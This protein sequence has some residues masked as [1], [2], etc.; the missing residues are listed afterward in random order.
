MIKIKLTALILTLCLSLPI[1]SQEQ[2]SAPSS[3]PPNL[4]EA[5]DK[6]DK[7]IK[8]FRSDVSA[9]FA[10]YPPR[11]SDKN[12]QSDTAA[13]SSPLQYA[14]DNCFMM[15]LNMGLKLYKDWSAYVD[16]GINDQN[17]QRTID[18]MAKFG[19]N[20]FD[21]ELEYYMANG[22]IKFWED[23]PFGQAADEAIKSRPPDQVSD[24]KETWQRV[25][26]LLKRPIRLG[27]VD[28]VP[29]GGFFYS[30]ATVPLVFGSEIAEVHEHL[31]A[32]AESAAAFFDPA[33]DVLALGIRLGMA[34]ITQHEPTFSRRIG[35]GA[36]YVNIGFG[37]VRPNKKL[38][39]QASALNPDFKTAALIAHFG[40]KIRLGMGYQ[41]FITRSAIFY[42]LGGLDMNVNVYHFPFNDYFLDVDFLPKTGG[43]GPYLRAGVKF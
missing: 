1:F 31:T 35:E 37:R 22:R 43:I 33:A 9:A 16:F 28:G 25:T 29:F 4:T 21:L 34:G 24:Y 41:T 30:N 6:V 10:W 23:T 38:T 17:A 7:K 2:T 27:G 3:P 20:F 36:F 13:P 15:Q 39:A 26:F 12:F 42:M 8:L 5:A 14:P 19:N 18:F 40:G 11:G 32:P